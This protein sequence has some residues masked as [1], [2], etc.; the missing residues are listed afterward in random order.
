MAGDIVHA[1]TDM[2]PELISVVSDFFKR[3]ADLAPTIVITGNHDCNL[4][5]NYR[6]DALSPIV[7]ALNHQNLHYLKDNGVY[8]MAGVHF[9]VM[10][11]FDKPVDYIKADSFE[12]DYKIALHHG[13]VHNASTD[14]GFV[15]SNT[16]VTTEIFK[17]HDLVLLGDIHKPQFLDDDKTIAYAGSLIQQNH[18]EALDHGILVWDLPDKSADFVEIENNYGYVTFEVDNAKI[19]NSPYRVPRK[20][21]VRIKFNDTDASETSA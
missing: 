21:R 7:K 17:G 18:G 2:S 1:K 14:A 13:S 16:H 10:S 19:I 4:N 20:P 9:N 15:L 3:L 6:L 12:G 11:V 8:S 5:N